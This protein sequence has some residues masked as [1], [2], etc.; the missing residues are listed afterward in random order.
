MK[1]NKNLRPNIEC[2]IMPTEYAKE[3]FLER[4]ISS[5]IMKYKL[6]IFHII[7]QFP[8]RHQFTPFEFVTAAP[9]VMMMM[10]M[11][12]ILLISRVLEGILIHMFFGFSP[13]ENS[14][15][16]ERHSE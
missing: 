7:W 1:E 13:D 16:F 11:N 5:V 10:M 12:S 8:E 2:F 15:V 6:V 14:F 4:P 9:M 3:S